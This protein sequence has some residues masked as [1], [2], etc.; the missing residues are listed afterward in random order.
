MENLIYGS[1]NRVLRFIGDVCLLIGSWFINLGSR[2][3]GF[4]EYE[5]DSDDDV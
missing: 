1:D 2:W 5:F 4:Y 3:G